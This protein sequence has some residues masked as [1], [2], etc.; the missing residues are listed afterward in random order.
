MT[1]FL[2]FLLLIICF[3]FSKQIALAK[4]NDAKLEGNKLFANGQYEEA[5]LKYELASKVAPDIPA[6]VEI[7]S[8]CH[9]NRAICLLKMVCTFSD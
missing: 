7:R 1:Q 2:P 8:I 9:G 4:A 5:L 3:S 6:S